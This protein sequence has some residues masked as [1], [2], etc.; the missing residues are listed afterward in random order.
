[1]T[2]TGWAAAGSAPNTPRGRSR[3]SDDGTATA[4]SRASSRKPAAAI[5]A[6]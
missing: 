6:T 1:M 2:I 5:W 4:G 3:I